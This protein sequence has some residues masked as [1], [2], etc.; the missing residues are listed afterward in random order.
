MVKSFSAGVSCFRRF[1]GLLPRPWQA[2]K[3]SVR[4]EGCHWTQVLNPSRDDYGVDIVSGRDAEAVIPA[5]AGIQYAA[6]SRFYHGV[7]GMLDRPPSRTM[8]AESVLAALIA[9]GLRVSLR[10][11]RKSEGA[12]NAGCALHP[13]S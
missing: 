7:S 8:T 11:L 6:A 1:S 4:R 3:Y 13:R 5:K 2:P 12:G 9:R 10:D